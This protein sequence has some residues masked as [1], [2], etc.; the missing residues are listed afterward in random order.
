MEVGESKTTVNESEYEKTDKTLIIINIIMIVAVNCD[1]YKPLRRGPRES[2]SAPTSLNSRGKAE[3]WLYY[4][5]FYTEEPRVGEI[6]RFELRASII[7]HL[8]VA[9][10]TTTAIA[11]GLERHSNV[12]RASRE[13]EQ[14]S[15]GER[16]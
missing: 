13:S 8:T 2:E 14:Q 1:R 16:E 5:A 15:D 7:L 9:A 3:R 4:F 10:A 6:S 11:T 12:S